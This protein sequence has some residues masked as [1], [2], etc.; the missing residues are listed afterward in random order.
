MAERNR[1]RTLDFL[2][3]EG[4]IYT[5]VD[6]P[7]G[8]VSSVPPIV[9]ATSDLAVV[10][11]HGRNA[12]RWQRGASSAA[13]RFEYLYTTDEL[14]EWVPKVHALAERTRE[15]HVLM[16]N[17]Y[18]DYAVRNASELAELLEQPSAGAESPPSTQPHA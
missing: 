14:R 5:C 15:V 8:F 10:R 2:G 1:V 16:N 3:H 9:A 18:S 7:Q 13:A 12:S 17:C 4:L 11:M 6:E